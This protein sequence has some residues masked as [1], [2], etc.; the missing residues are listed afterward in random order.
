MVKRGGAKGGW[1]A[2]ILTTLTA[3]LGISVWLGIGILLA[4]WQQNIQTRGSGLP[5]AHSSLPFAVAAGGSGLSLLLALLVYLL[6]TAR[7]RA[8]AAV[9]VAT[10]DLRDQAIL[11]AAIMNSVG[12]GVLVVDHRGEFILYNPAARQYLEADSDAPDMPAD[13]VWDRQSEIFRPDGVTPFPHAELPMARALLGESTQGVEVVVR[14]AD[15]SQEYVVSVSA[16]PLDDRAG[17]PGAV[18]VFHDITARKRGEEAISRTATRLAIELTRRAETETELRAR[19][20]ELTDFA[21]VVAHD[22]KTPLLAV[23]GFTELLR[24]DLADGRPEGLDTASGESMDK[25]TAGVQRMSQL[26]DDLLTFATS[27]D[28]SLHPESVDLQALVAQIITERTS[29]PRSSGSSRLRPEIEVGPLPNVQA[30]PMMCR[31]LLDN[32]IGNALKY[33][34][35]GQAAQI[36]ISAQLE[37]GPTVRVE[38]A[39]HGVGIPPGEHAN[40]FASFH[41]AHTGSA[42]LGTGLGLAI[43]QRIVDRHGGTIGVGDNPG[44]GSCFHFSLPFASGAPDASSLPAATSTST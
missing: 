31:Q 19:E 22:L 36:K 39:D 5:G 40:V 32:L 9:A 23:A 30:D 4:R 16:Q 41:R 8:V 1:L 12:E 6:A 7:A 10:A 14:R 25:I 34:L 38:I 2:P 21:G 37:A 43:C 17:R 3:V 35:P 27:R 15:G 42:Y 28:R 18:A 20:A 33:T 11:L 24:Y 44:G 13:M 29:Y 26:I